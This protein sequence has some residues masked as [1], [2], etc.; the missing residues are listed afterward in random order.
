MTM[1]FTSRR[2]IRHNSEGRPARVGALHHSPRWISKKRSVE[3]DAVCLLQVPWP[4]GRPLKLSHCHQCSQTPLRPNFLNGSFM[5]S[6]KKKK[7]W[8]LEF[9]LWLSGLASMRMQVWSLALFSGLRIPHWRKL[10]CRSQID[11]AQI[12]CCCGGVWWCVVWLW[13]G[14]SGLDL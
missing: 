11:A 10:W 7:K 14:C 1:I 13:C 6:F 12:W 5:W 2:L 8:K 3:E 9:P 4:P